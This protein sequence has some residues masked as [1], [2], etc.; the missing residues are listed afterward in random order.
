LVHGNLLIVF[1]GGKPG[2][3]VV[4][5]DKRT[6]REIWKALDDTVSNS[7]P[8]ILA[9]GGNRQLIAWTANAVSSLNPETGAIWWRMPM[10]TSGNDS[11]PTPVVQKNRLLISGLMLEL[12]DHL[13]DAHVLWPETLAVPKRLLSNTSSPLLQGAYIYSAR[14][15]GEFVCLEAATGNQLWGT[16]NVT[17]LKFGA[18]IQLTPNG[19]TT[20]LFTDEGNL[21]ITQL[22]PDGYRE[23]GRVHLLK[24]TSHL[25]SRKLAWV[26]PAFANRCIFARN[27]EELICASLKAR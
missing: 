22:T 15:S 2:A 13:P 20:F 27:D 7:S 14:S 25:G 26:P 8:L 21:I 17:E 6:G 9:A 1:I 19:D 10:T 18:S 3:C 23:T 4:A 24:P 5:L 11:I 12:D 16:T